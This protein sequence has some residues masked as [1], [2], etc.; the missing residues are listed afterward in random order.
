MVYVDFVT[1]QEKQVRGEFINRNITGTLAED[2]S[3]YELIINKTKPNDDDLYT[4]RIKT[5][6]SWEFVEASVNLTLVGEF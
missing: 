2:E 1:N 4:C 6:S 3:S 5:R